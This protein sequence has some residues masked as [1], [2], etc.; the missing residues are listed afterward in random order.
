[1]NN[2]LIQSIA[3]VA[4]LIITASY[5]FKNK[6][7]FVILQI[8]SYVL[9]SIH[10]YLLGGITGALA[11]I[12]SIFILL[13]IMYKEKTKKPC[14]FIIGIIFVLF[15]IDL[16]ISYDGIASIISVLACVLPILTNW[17][18][19]FYIIKMGGIIGAIL[20]LIYAIFYGSYS[21]IIMNIIFIII[22]LYSIYKQRKDEKNDKLQRKNK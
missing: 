11:N 10:L 7:H 2:T 18:N 14:Y 5:Y 20:W 15:G 17:Q 16:F 3:I 6:L 19:N 9:Y 4:W 12:F 21:I 8:I 13:L 22:T 1:M